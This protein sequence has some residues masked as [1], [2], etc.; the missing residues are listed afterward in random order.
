MQTSVNAGK[1]I[2][3]VEDDE[4]ITL[5]LEMNLRAEGYRVSVAV[6]GESA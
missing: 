6:D 4:S 3:I 2:L 1:H 5:G